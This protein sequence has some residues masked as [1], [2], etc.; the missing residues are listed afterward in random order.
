MRFSLRRG[1]FV[2]VTALCF[3]ALPAAK[4][5]AADRD[6]IRQARNAYYSLQAR[7]F[8]DLRCDVTPNWRA[9]LQVQLKT[10]PAAVDLLK[11]PVF[12]VR[13]ASGMQAKIAHNTIAAANDKMVQGLQQIYS[14]ME[15][16]VVGFFATWTGYVVTPLLP[17]AGDDYHL[18]EQGGRSRL[19]YKEGPTDVV[20]IMEKDFSND[21]TTVDA[22]RFVSVLR[23]TFTRTSEG[24]L[25]T[26]YSGDYR[27]KSPN[28]PDAV[29][30]HVLI[31]YQQVNG[32][33]L[34]SKLNISGSQNGQPVQVEV[35]F[36]GCTATKHWSVA[37]AS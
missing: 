23:P 25:L 17:A 20:I 18:Q 26:E 19:S 1:C 10:N 35:A 21:E 24:L 29:L 6:I 31:A 15:Q 11:Q 12:V 13:L 9:I 36:S 37:L 16:M 30:L 22:P 3:F 5:S 32:L 8:V 14:G 4:A 2:A 7:G 28:A 27:G 34:P 33:Q